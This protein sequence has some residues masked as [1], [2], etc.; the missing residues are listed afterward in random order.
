MIFSVVSAAVSTPQGQQPPPQPTPQPVEPGSETQRNEPSVQG[1]EEIEIVVTGE[2]ET[3]YR[4]PDAS[5]ATR[6]DTPL[7]DIPQSIQV[8]PQQVIQDQQA[9]RL[10]EVLKNAPGVVVGDRS[11]RDPLNIFKIRGK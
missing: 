9:T 6:T 4:V 11:P 2:Q 7:R 1:E 3:G 10:T 8:I 5:T